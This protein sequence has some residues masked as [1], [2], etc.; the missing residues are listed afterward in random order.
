MTSP[1]ER[2]NNS[3]R[4]IKGKR[5]LFTLSINTYPPPN[6]STT[7]P[8]EMLIDYVRLYQLKTDCNNL[9]K[10]IFFKKKIFKINNYGNLSQKVN[11]N[12]SSMLCAYEFAHYLQ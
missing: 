12:N 1:T 5:I 9:I 8:S 6:A 10:I 3:I 2:L 4:S 11:C 7:F